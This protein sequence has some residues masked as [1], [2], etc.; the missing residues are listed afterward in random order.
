[1]P[2]VSVIIPF[3]DTPE[4]FITQAI[5]SVIAQRY[6]NWEILL[7]DDGSTGR[8]TPVAQGY[9]QA[10]PARV[11]YLEHPG[12]E[13]RGL[14]ASRSLGFRH[15]KGKFI[16][17]LDADDVWFPNKLEDQV[18]ILDAQ[19]QAGM[20]YGRTQYWWSW[21]GNVEDRERDR[22]QDHGIRADALVKPPLL[23]ML[24]LRGKAAVPPP[25]SILVQRV[26]MEASGGFE[27]FGEPDMVGHA[28]TP[29]ERRAMV[30][31]LNNL[32][33]DQVFYAKIC[34]ETPVFVSNDCWDRYR[35]HPESLCAVATSEQNRF[36]RLTY[37]AWLEQY[38]SKHGLRDTKVWRALRSEMW[39]RRHPGIGL[40]VK[41]AQRFMWRM[42][43]NYPRC[44]NKR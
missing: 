24:F 30:S 25:S 12:H 42:Q 37:L 44:V 40:R 9:A 22:I 10:N 28:R 17:F 15:A 5:E 6:G 14:S 16:A 18:A 7:V 21:T 27:T 23:L 4:P 34:L 33:E 11:K 13:N 1:M 41:C 35:Q 38:L 29:E 32:Y 39:F 36:A 26:V 19:P 31:C 43:G 20:I 2:L 8:C 3:Y